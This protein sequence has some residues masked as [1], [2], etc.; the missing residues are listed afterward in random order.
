FAEDEVTEWLSDAG[1]PSATPGPPSGAE[2]PRPAS[3]RPAARRGV[4]RTAL[5]MGLVLIGGALAAAAVR[6]LS[7][8]PGSAQSSAAIARQQAEARAAAASWVA[9]EVSRDA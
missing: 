9:R 6:S 7:R 2:P 4:R 8:P 5:A 3:S 1:Q